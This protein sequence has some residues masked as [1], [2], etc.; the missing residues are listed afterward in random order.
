MSS[1][2]RLVCAVLLLLGGI[3]L[4]SLSLQRISGGLFNRLLRDMANT[5]LKG[6]SL[7]VAST[8]FL[9]SSSAVSV[10]TI[11]FING[12][13]LTLYQG[14]SI[15]IG[16]N[17]G[18]TLTS[19][20]FTLELRMLLLPL[21]ITGSI[22]F[23]MGL[24][25]KRDMGGKVLLG[26]GLVLAGIEMLIWILGGLTMAPF[27]QKVLLFSRGAPWQGLLTGIFLAG[28]LQS[29]SVTVG[30]V[31]LLAREGILTL[32]QALA[33][34]LGAD[35]GTCVT[36]LLATV[37][38]ILPAKQ[39]AWGHVAFNFISIFLILPLW[40]YFI[41]FVEYT[42]ADIGRQV[43]NAHLF[44]NILGAVIMLPLIDYYVIYYRN[45][46]LPEK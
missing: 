5:K 36:S 23:F 12:S 35:L 9:Q 45:K 37:G 4:L 44:Y 8:F 31:V 13:F 33:V 6:F 29:S 38:T 42:A 34:V 28:I 11:A 20:L 32:P 21:A 43:A 19:Q 39:L 26:I 14:L 18:T 46:I 25:V 15:M 2:L 1:L 7:G 41:W 17:V 3:R 27:F 24:V 16:A 22:L 40:P 10:I 30:I